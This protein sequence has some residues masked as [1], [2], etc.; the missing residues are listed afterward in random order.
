MEAL[1][2]EAETSVA[3][4]SRPLVQ[5]VKYQMARPWFLTILAATGLCAVYLLGVLL[6]WGDVGERSLYANLGMLPVGLAATLLA[7]STAQGQSDH[8]SKTAWRLLSLGFAGFFVGD[9]LYFYYQNIRG[10]TPFPSAADAAYLAYYPLMFAG[11]VCLS[12][13]GRDRVRLGFLSVNL[14][15]FIGAGGAMLVYFYLVPTLGSPRDDLLAYSLS[16]G[17]PVGDLFLLAGLAAL[18]IRRGTDHID[19][20]LWLLGAGLIVGL[21]ADVVFGYQGIQG[22]LQAGGLSDAGYMVSWILF[23][24]A[25]YL[26]F[27]RTNRESAVRGAAE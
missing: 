19:G 14:N 16:A 11:L 18:L 17:Y 27:A 12:R 1:I 9:F 21:G 10:T 23:G 3:H 20:S 24:W 25:S 13:R 2:A 22:A 8:R 5:A 6:N 4:R 26:E 15:V 7:W